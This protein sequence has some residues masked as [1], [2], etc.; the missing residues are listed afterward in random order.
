MRYRSVTVTNSAAQRE[1]VHG[2]RG[3][4]DDRGI[5]LVLAL[6]VMLVLSVMGTAFLALSGTETAISR[7]SQVVAQAF[8]AAEA[9]IDTA[10]S[11]LPSL[12]SIPQ[13]PVDPNGNANVVF[14]TPAAPV[15]LGP[16]PVPIAGYNLA[17]YSFNMFQI[18]VTGTVILPR[19]D[20]RLQV[21]TTL[22]SPLAGT[23]YN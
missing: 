11:L 16:S 9:G 7:N 13:T 2:Q 3:A 12:N 17:N 15:G 5:V 4:P 23:S 18:N 21:G 14:Q 20:V 19:S 22:G 6:L 10:I 1:A 8:Y